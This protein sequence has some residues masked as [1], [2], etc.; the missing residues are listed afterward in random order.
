MENPYLD[1]VVEFLIP[2][3][4]FPNFD[5]AFFEAAFPGHELLILLDGARH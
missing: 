4:L 1:S 3:L 5:D 2:E